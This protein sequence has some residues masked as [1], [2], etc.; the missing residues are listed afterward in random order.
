MSDILYQNLCNEGV[1]CCLWS[2]LSNSWTR[3]ISNNNVQLT[4]MC[5]RNK[6]LQRI[7]SYLIVNKNTEIQPIR[8][9]RN[10][11]VPE[12][13]LNS[14][15][16]FFTIMIRWSCPIISPVTFSNKLHNWVYKNI[17]L[18]MDSDYRF[19]IHVKSTLYCHTMLCKNNH[20]LSLPI[21]LHQGL[22]IDITIWC[23]LIYSTWNGLHLAWNRFCASYQ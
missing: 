14:F 5:S 6:A 1:I 19:L 11:V 17:H 4:K 10:E 16:K 13:S 22:I 21:Y 9:N 3:H 15:E 12:K 2:C 18:T 20:L 8:D 23:N 7:R